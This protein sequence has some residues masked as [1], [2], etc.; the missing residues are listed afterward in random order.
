MS[1]PLAQPFFPMEAKSATEI[2]SGP[3]WE[4]EPK[5]DGFR[6]IVFRDGDSVELQSKA[7]KPL[8]RYFPEIVESM[9]KVKAK[10]FVLDGELIIPRKGK[11]SFDDLLQRIHP[12]AS[13]IAKLSAET[14]AQYIVFDLLV[15]DKGK[16]LVKENLSE[17]RPALESLHRRILAADDRVRLSRSTGDLEVA[18]SWLDKLRG[19]LDGVI[20]KR[21]D[22]PY[23]SG[24][25]AMQKIK[26]MRTADCVV[27]GF[28]YGTGSKNVGSLLLG[29]YNKGLLDHVGFTSSIAASSRAALTKKLE[30]LIQ[31]PGFTGGAPG[32][33]SRWSTD[34]STEWEPLK[35]VLVAEVQFDHFTGGRFR[36]GTKFLRWRPDKDPKQC[37]MKQV[38]Y[39]SSVPLKLL[40]VTGKRK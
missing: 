18:R 30:K 8:T 32:G 16:S 31:P 37:T 35:P 21:L 6:C 11:L 29:L 20:A 4:Y 27:G 33:P 19:Q 36:H 22:Q 23:L 34:R 17:R 1:L 15:D 24:E 13:R 5:W 12:A 25:R 7:G 10:Q 26:N 14:P 38:E 2:P 40:T 39:D 28:R 3:E 9:R